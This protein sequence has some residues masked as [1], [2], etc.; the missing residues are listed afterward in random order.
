[1]FLLFTPQSVF[2]TDAEELRDRLSTQR[3]RMAELSADQAANNADVTIELER[4]RGDIDEASD[5]LSNNREAEAEV[6]VIR[7]ENRVE[8]IAALIEQATMEA[9]AE[10]REAALIEMTREADQASVE[11]TSTEARR[12]AL[13]DEVSGIIQQLEMSND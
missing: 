11:Y 3:E 8:L 10:D 6:S 13:R 9:L 1:M 2:A 12:S 5:R 4:A 7:L